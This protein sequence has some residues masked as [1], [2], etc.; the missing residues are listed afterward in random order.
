MRR[1]GYGAAAVLAVA[2]WLLLVLAAAP[3]VVRAQ[4]APPDDPPA[5]PVGWAP[6]DLGALGRETAEAIR[7]AGAGGMTTEAFMGAL[8]IGKAAASARLTDAEAAG[9]VRRS[10]RGGRQGPQV[11][12]VLARTTGDRA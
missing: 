3:A 9:L 1:R 8:R 7:A 11:W 2:V 6:P 5:A 12:R 10:G 4:E